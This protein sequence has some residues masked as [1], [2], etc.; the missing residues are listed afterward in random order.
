MV[1]SKRKPDDKICV[2]VDSEYIEAM[3]IYA[4]KAKRVIPALNKLAKDVG[5][6]DVRW[7]IMDS[8]DIHRSVY[9][10]F[11]SCK[12]K[13][14]SYIAL[15]DGVC[16]VEEYSSMY[17]T[18]RGDEYPVK[19][20]KFL[21]DKLKRKLTEYEA[22]CIRRDGEYFIIESENLSGFEEKT[23]NRILDMA[24]NDIKEYGGIQ[25]ERKCN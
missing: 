21:W 22:S 25:Y 12:A 18:L 24:E 20:M 2:Y 11:I 13:R 23:I 19:G 7:T 9:K 17:Y 10:Q 16:S 15:M 14:K 4:F 8:G 6:K 1:H 5:D 3:G